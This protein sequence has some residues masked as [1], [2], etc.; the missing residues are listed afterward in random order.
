VSW[1]RKPFVKLT[2]ARATSGESTGLK[3]ARIIR[4]E[5]KMSI[6][7]TFRAI[8]REEL[9]TL[10][11]TTGS[12]STVEDRLLSASQA[13]EVMQVSER[14]LYK[15]ADRLPYAV[16]LSSNVVRFSHNKIQ[17]EIARRL[18]AQQTNGNR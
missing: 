13:A 3:E 16:K 10:V 18:R 14:W 15:H 7:E 9:A 8:I 2:P 11:K 17:E 12:R 6:E 1:R 4:T 5:K